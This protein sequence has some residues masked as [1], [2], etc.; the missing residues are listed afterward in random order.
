MEG[1]IKL[2]RKILNWEW[3]KEDN[4]FRVFIYLLSSANYKTSKWRGITVNRGQVITGRSVIAEDLGI[5][6][7]S[8]RTCLSRLKSTSE[9]TVKSTNKYSIVTV[10][11]YEEYQ[12][13]GN[14]NDQQN[15]QQSVQQA[16]NKRP[17]T[18]HIQ[19]YK[20]D[21]K[22]EKERIKKAEILKKQREEEEL[23]REKETKDFID[24][25][26]NDRI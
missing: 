9:I 24:D 26:M 21:K 22:V 12:F 19:E 1:W 6:E 16:T 8:V 5:S 2:H 15:D 7:R 13:I 4:T 11:K 10:C 18:D 17:A 25:L 14:Y 23:K 3:F 20:E